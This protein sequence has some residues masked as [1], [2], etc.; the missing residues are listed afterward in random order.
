L[1]YA[2]SRSRNAS[3]F[4][5]PLAIAAQDAPAGFQLRNRMRGLPCC[6]AMAISAF[7]GKSCLVPLWYA[8]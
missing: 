3:V 5:S 7:V 1:M 2:A 6:R 4:G 8:W